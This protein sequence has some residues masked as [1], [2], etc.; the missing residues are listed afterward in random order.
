MTND[1][2]KI[3]LS[4]IDDLRKDVGEVREHV[5]AIDERTSH[6]PTRDDMQRSIVEHS[7]H[8]EH[9]RRWAI[10]LIL[11]L[12]AMAAAAVAVWVSIAN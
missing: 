6:M 2:T 8:C 4:A 10:S 12:P 11:G 3:I 5:A 1:T 9:R 7:Q